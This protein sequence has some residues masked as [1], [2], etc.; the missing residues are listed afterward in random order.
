MSD[1]SNERRIQRVLFAIG[2]FVIGYTFVYGEA[3]FM[4]PQLVPLFALA[5]GLGLAIFLWIRSKK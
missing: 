4:E 1:G 5:L 3:R 2:L